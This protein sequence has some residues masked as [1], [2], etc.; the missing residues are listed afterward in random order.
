MYPGVFPAHTEHWFVVEVMGE[1]TY[2]TRCTILVRLRFGIFVISSLNIHVLK[3][4]IIPATKRRRARLIGTLHTW[5]PNFCRPVIKTKDM[6]LG[7]YL[8][9]PVVYL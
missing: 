4:E 8:Q 6:L 1:R 9:C 5:S 3:G 2:R 7:N